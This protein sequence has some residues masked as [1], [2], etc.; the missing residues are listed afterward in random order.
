[1]NLI[2][3]LNAPSLLAE[4]AAPT[5]GGLETG[6]VLLGLLVVAVLWLASS[7]CQLRNEVES[8]K[9]LLAEKPRAV[10]AAPGRGGSER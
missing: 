4:A 7:V 1:M 3:K 5:A 10:S 9:D 8:L 6:T 2:L